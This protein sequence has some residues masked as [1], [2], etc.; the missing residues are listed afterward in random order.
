[1]DSPQF[2]FN[3]GLAYMR[4]K[5]FNEAISEFSGAMTGLD[6]KAECFI[7]LSECHMALGRFE[8]A[9]DQIG[10]ALKL[11]NLTEQDRLSLIYQSALVYKKKGDLKRALK[12]F[13]KVY[14]ADR[15]FRSVDTEI[16]NLQLRS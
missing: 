2:H 4:F 6:N 9:I 1:M 7:K 5:E 15:N 3:F 12:A 11:M 10:K 14:A 16:K 8:V 13:Q